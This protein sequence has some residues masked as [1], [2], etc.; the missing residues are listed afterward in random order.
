M[1]E[2]VELWSRIKEQCWPSHAPS[3]CVPSDGEWFC[4][5]CDITFKTK[6]ALASHQAIVHGCRNQIRSLVATSVC[7]I[8]SV[9][10]HSRLRAVQHIQRS[11]GCKLSL[12]SGEVEPPT[13]EALAQA[14]KD[15]QAWR[16]TCRRNGWSNLSGPP[17]ER[18]W[19]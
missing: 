16:V 7:P 4:P 5:T 11:F 10:Y 9:Q 3:Q 17:C 18:P 13:A 2:D 14:D 8:C 19:G 1:G 15:E 6:A 12:L